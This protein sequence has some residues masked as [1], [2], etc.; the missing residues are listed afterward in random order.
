MKYSKSFNEAYNFYLANLD[1]FNF[2]GTLNPKF[3]AVY[4]PDG[5]SAKQAFYHIESSGMNP[6]C[7]E[8]DLLNK[9]LLT[10]AGINFQI[11]Q[12]AEGRAEGTLPLIEFCADRVPEYDGSTYTLEWV[13]GEPVKHKDIKTQYVLPEWV[14]NA[15]ENQKRRLYV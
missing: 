1:I 8:P 4:S 11:K 7:R 15:V 6:F 10:K 14:I 13:N 2:C 5:M 3:T 12:W 9:L